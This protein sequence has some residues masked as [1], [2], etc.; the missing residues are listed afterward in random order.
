M[1]I[2]KLMDPIG[3]FVILITSFFTSKKWI[4]PIS[5]V[6]GAIIVETILTANQYNRDWGSGLLIGLFASSVHAYTC[7]LFIWK[8]IKNNEKTTPVLDDEQNKS[9]VVLVDKHLKVM[10]YKLTSYGAGVALLGMNSGYNEVETASQIALTTM[11]LDI[12]NAGSDI[13]QLASF[14]PHAHALLEIL[15]NYKDSGMMHPTQWKNDTNAI[16]RICTVD[17]YQKEWVEKI[18]SDPIAGRN[19]LAFSLIAEE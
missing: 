11:A 19:R 4:I 10:G 3:F 6:T 16:F 18:L 8:Y 13:V 14:V 15:R 12:N 9:F 5:A 2:A 17:K 1:F 7:Y